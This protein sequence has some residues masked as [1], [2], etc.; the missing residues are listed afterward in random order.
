MTAKIVFLNGPPHSGKDTLAGFIQIQYKNI[1]R[2]KFAS[3]LKIACHEILGLDVNEDAYENAKNIESPDFFGKTPREFYIQMSETF[4][5][6]KFG[7][8]VFGYVW[9]RRNRH[10][11]D[12]MNLIIVSDCGFEGELLPIL[13]HVDESDCCIIRLH[14]QDCDYSKDSR[15]YVRGVVSKEADIVNVPGT[16]EFMFNHFVKQMARWGFSDYLQ[17]RTSVLQD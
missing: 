16:P 3:P 15:G 8:D 4:M 1:A 14:R 2:T 7:T 13:K 11:L 12:A 10:F 6:P 9:L 17:L 5:K